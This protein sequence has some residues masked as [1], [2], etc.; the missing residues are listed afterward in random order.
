MKVH[1]FKPSGLD[2]FRD[3]LVSFKTT[4]DSSPLHEMLQDP[5]HT[6]F[7][8]GRQGNIEIEPRSFGTR[9]DVAEYLYPLLSGSY[10]G[11]LWSDAG[12]WA[13]LSAFYFD[14]LCK[15]NPEGIR[16]P[17]NL[18]RWIPE[19]D[20]FKRYYRHLLAGPCRIFE[21]FSDNIDL[22]MA[23]LCTPVDRPGAVVEEIASRQPFVTNKGIVGAVT[24]LYYDKTRRTHKR[25]A[26][27]KGPG[28]ARR[29]PIVLSQY[30]LTWDLYS[31][32]A[33]TLLEMLPSE[34]DRYKL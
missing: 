10:E 3:Y 23:L 25:G 4:Q 7:A 5:E 12:L 17:Q 22:A 18:S 20:D 29:F 32:D 26:G 16:D 27:G 1:C 11:N 34:F 31:M 19:V 21:T 24:M 14:S 28:S 30:E 6:I 13:W 9:L 2:W 15:V 8:R 33:G